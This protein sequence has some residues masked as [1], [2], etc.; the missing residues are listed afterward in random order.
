MLLEN[1]DNENERGKNIG[2][3]CNA[4]QRYKQLGHKNLTHLCRPFEHVRHAVPAKLLV[5]S[6]HVK[7][8]CANPTASPTHPAGH[9]LKPVQDVST[10]LLVQSVRYDPGGTRTS[11]APP[12]STMVSA[13]DSMHWVDPSS[14]ASWPAEHSVQL[15]SLRGVAENFPG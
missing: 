2:K 7:Q 5:P 14:A 12:P 3:M 15:S 4:I 6:S 10:S 13:P 11:A 8:C 1:I 9:C